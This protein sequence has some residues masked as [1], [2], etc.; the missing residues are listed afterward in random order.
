MSRV[1]SRGR[2]PKCRPKKPSHQSNF[3]IISMLPYII[4][5][6]LLGSFRKKNGL[7]LSSDTLSIK[8]RLRVTYIQ[9]V[10]S[11]RRQEGGLNAWYLVLFCLDLLWVISSP[12]LHG[13]LV[14]EK[15]EGKGGLV[16]RKTDMLQKG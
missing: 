7:L 1:G 4:H 9:E 16:Y 11:M 2:H 13:E 14:P 10:N 6:S 12:G 3:I 5:C 8:K 15:G